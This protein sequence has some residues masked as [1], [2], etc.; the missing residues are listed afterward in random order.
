MA[1]LFAAFYFLLLRPQQKK[2]IAHTALEARRQVG[3][4]ILTAWGILVNITDDSDYYAAVSLGVNTEIKI[5]KSSVTMV[6]PKGTYD[7]A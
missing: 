5:K 4:E 3:D 1:L 7:E 2:Q 6:V